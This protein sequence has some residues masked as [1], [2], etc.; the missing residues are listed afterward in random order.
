MDPILLKY[1]NVS[2]TVFLEFY[3][4]LTESLSLR[5]FFAVPRPSARE[6]RPGGLRV[7][8]NGRPR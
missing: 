1:S 2:Y 6:A 8:G 3:F 7:Q 4:P 5:L